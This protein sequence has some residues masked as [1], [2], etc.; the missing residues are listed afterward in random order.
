M[1]IKILRAHSAERESMTLI[2]Q[3]LRTTE[4]AF[5]INNQN[6]ARVALAE[7][8]RGTTTLIIEILHAKRA[9]SVEESLSHR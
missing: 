2:V 4:A 6:P 7:G 9:Q 3:I 5:D 8:R 1:I